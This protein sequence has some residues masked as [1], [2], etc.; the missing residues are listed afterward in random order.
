M[1]GAFWW[2]LIIG[3]CLAGAVVLLAY[4]A[5]GKEGPCSSETSFAR[6]VDQTRTNFRVEHQSFPPSQRCVAVAPS[7]GVVASETYPRPAEWLLAGLAAISPFL[8]A[9]AYRALRRRPAR[10]ESRRDEPTG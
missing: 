1:S 9:W 3:W 5:G 8:A 6:S 10:L 2:K 4:N 7:G